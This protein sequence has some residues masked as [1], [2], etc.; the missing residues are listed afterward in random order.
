M[1]EQTGECA[2]CSNI[3]LAKNEIVRYNCQ[4]GDTKNNLLYTHTHTQN[5]YKHI[6]YY[7][8]HKKQPL[9]LSYNQFMCSVD[10]QGKINTYYLHKRKGLHCFNK[11]GDI[12][13]STAL[14]Y[15]ILIF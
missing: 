7:Y 13:Y 2:V 15:W 14:L 6:L 11:L 8:K 3:I 12:R 9:P 4:M 10:H 1:E 5:Y